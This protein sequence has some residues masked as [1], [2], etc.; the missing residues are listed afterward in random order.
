MTNLVA[1][2][3]TDQEGKK[4]GQPDGDYIEACQP[5]LEELIEIADPKLIVT[6]G[7]LARKWM[8]QGFK[9][10]VRVNPKI[11]FCDIIHPA[12]ILRANISQRDITVQRCIITIQKAIEE[13][14][15]PKYVPPTPRVR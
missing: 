11:S 8:E 6:V 13:V 5:R 10:S 2:I 1:C 7:A 15:D 14:L 4:A 9:S 3:P 12:A